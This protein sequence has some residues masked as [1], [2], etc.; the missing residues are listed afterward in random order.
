LDFEEDIRQHV[1]AN[2]P[3][4]PAAEQELAARDA[5]VLLAIFRNWLSR[6]VWPQPRR[7]H[8]SRALISNPIAED[9]RYRPALEQI[10]NN[11][12]GGVEV[13]PHLSRDLKHGYQR[14]QGP[15][16]MP[17]SRRHDL[18]LLLNDWNVHHLH[19][20]TRIEADG[21][22]KRTRPLL[23]AVFRPNDAYLID[24]MHHGDWT[25]SHVLEVIIGE[26]PEAGLVRELK[27]VLRLETTVSEDDRAKLRNSGI[28]TM[29]EFNG[30]VY[31]PAG[32]ITGAGTSVHTTVIVNEVFRNIDWFRRELERDQ[33]FV[34]KALAEKGV[35]TSA[36]DLHFAFFENGGYGI[37]ERQTGFRF[38]FQR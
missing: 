15:K 20:S 13:T 23:F 18:D 3:H 8:R 4:E 37:V 5:W 29:F 1:I 25:R 38:R 16:P 10:I 14:S 24:V 6:F 35:S 32:G 28:S 22:V 9:S 2:L 26:W 31:A 19:L 27:G 12:E 34:S 11:L 21:F 17:L 30:K 36:P 7:V 33:E